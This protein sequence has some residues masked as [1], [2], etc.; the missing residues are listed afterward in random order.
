MSAASTSMLMT[1]HARSSP[2]SH[3]L[4]LLNPLLA[5]LIPLCP[6]LDG[7][8]EVSSSAGS[9]SPAF[10]IVFFKIGFWGATLSMHESTND[11]PKNHLIT[12]SACWSMLQQLFAHAAKG[13]Q[14]L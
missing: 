14:T 11:K 1:S 9:D 4:S 10:G 5:L 6:P 8:L 13:H 12:A 7:S 3:V 2:H